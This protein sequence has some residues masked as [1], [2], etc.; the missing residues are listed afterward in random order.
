MR[1]SLFVGALCLV[2]TLPSGCMLLV[3]ALAVPS[4]SASGSF[5]A[6]GGSLA[7]ISLSL[8]SPPSGGGSTSDEK[9]SYSRD[10][11]QYVGLFMASKGT[12]RDFERGVSRIAEAHGIAHWEAEPATAYAIGQGLAQAGVSAQQMSELGESLTSNEATAQQVLDGWR[13]VAEAR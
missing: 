11:R 1:R 5:T 3:D 6:I 8:G 10:L 9:Q 4:E 12:R 2:A 13:N 7:G